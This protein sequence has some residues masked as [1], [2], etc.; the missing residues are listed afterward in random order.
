MAKVKKTNDRPVTTSKVKQNQRDENQKKMTEEP[1]DKPPT[2]K[3]NLNGVP[4]HYSAKA[5]RTAKPKNEN[6]PASG[7]QTANA[8]TPTSPASVAKTGPPRESTAH[9]SD[10]AV[11]LD[12]NDQ[13]SRAGNAS[14]T[15]G[16]SS[17][18]APASGTVPA[19]STAGSTGPSA[20]AIPT[21]ATPTKESATTSAPAAPFTAATGATPA[22]APPAETGAVT[23]TPGDDGP[24]GPN[25]VHLG[26][27]GKQL[28]SAPLIPLEKINALN[29]PDLTFNG[30][31]DD[32][33]FP[34]SFANDDGTINEQ[35]AAKAL[36][37]MKENDFNSVR[38]GINTTTVNDPENFE[39][40]TNIV[41]FLTDN[42]LHVMFAG[43]KGNTV[44]PV[45]ERGTGK[46]LKEGT[47]DGQEIAPPGKDVDGDGKPDRQEFFDMWTKVAETFKDNQSVVGYEL[48]NEP[49]SGGPRRQKFGKGGPGY[50]PTDKGAQ[51][52]ADDLQALYDHVERQTGWGSS[53]YIMVQGLRA[54]E[55]ITPL[56]GENRPLK[57]VDNLVLT[58]HAYPW[59]NERGNLVTKEQ[60]KEHWA[61]Q[62]E[63]A[64]DTPVFFSE[65]GVKTNITDFSA[66]SANDAATGT[67]PGLDTPV[68]KKQQRRNWAMLNA[69]A[70]FFSEHNLGSVYHAFS[71]PPGGGGGRGLTDS[72]ISVISQDVVEL[73][74]TAQADT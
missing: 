26:E 74:K 70:E 64:G 16:T 33:N 66:D 43:F 34:L 72:E 58:L 2:K 15:S 38:L 62:L 37:F 52:Y 73:V 32:A 29:V 12:S 17:G 8:P 25:R 36:A 55:D 45:K 47:V 31:E 23:V 61:Q 24:Y 27:N 1:K 53:K 10:G 49:A 28:A 69:A 7:S 22:A 14:R 30:V 5:T 4:G 56:A 13:S 59:R 19:P 57:D 39:K 71:S 51:R 44:K 6:K 60:W 35:R 20:G 40:F 42:D 41:N 65:F 46:I 3:R 67:R 50:A 54:G 21:G 11:G 63:T 48:L 18:S 68:D 9:P